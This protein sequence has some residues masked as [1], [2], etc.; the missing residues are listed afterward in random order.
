MVNKPQT[1]MYTFTW[2]GL[3]KAGSRVK[4]ESQNTNPALVRAE[5][6]QQGINPLK[7]RKK[8]TIFAMMT[9]KKIRSMDITLFTRQ[10]A[11]MLTAGIPLIQ[12]FDLIARGQ[13][14]LTMQQLV[15]S[16]KQDVE[17]G[18]SF[19]EA[20]KKH[21]EYFNKLYV[22]LIYAGEQSGSLELMLQRVSDYREKIESLKGKIRKAMYYPAAVLS[23]AVIVTAILLIFVVPEF[24]DLFKGFGADLPAMTRMVI[25]L[26]NS[27]QN[28]IWILL[29][30]LILTIWIFLQAKQRSENF[31][32]TL[33]R[34]A[35]RLPIMGNILQKAI[36]A[37]FSRTL[38]TTFAAG[39]PLVSALDVVAGATGNSL[40]IEGT[41][42]IRDEISTGQ[43][44]QA[45]M[46]NT[47][48]FPSM[49]IQ[50]VAIGEESGTLEMML[51]KIADF[52]EEEVDN[53]VDSLSS[54]LEP[55][56]IVILGIIVGTLVIAMY[57]PIFKLGAAIH[58]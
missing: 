56:I 7:V 22:N 24:E 46:R 41:L 8:S 57:L 30:S 33:D 48:L 14:K 4:G 17:N 32:K 54:I 49:V 47:Q 9:S 42:K 55:I 13:N 43:Q 58:G 36:I 1:K 16:I 53:A 6:R 3:N 27:L 26:S 10:L 34:I 28:H 38:A 50:M 35:L 52:H 18:S 37:R 12:A 2:E 25:S 19:S 51:S 44:L 29:A 40:Y 23:V 39:I 15:T 31:N 21:P 5:L 20:L 45:A 11:T